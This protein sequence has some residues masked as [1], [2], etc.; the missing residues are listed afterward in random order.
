MFIHSFPQF[1]FGLPNILGF[2]FQT[3]DK[4]HHVVCETGSTTSHPFF[5]QFL[6]EGGSNGVTFGQN[7]TVPA[8]NGRASD[9]F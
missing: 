2:A 4:I 1:A 6:E 8:G 9:V 7:P 3:D 5:P